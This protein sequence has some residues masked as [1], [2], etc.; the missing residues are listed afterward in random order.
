MQSI[1]SLSD[2]ELLAR[3]PD[4]VRTERGAMADVIVHL[5]EIGRRRLYLDQACSS[6]YSYCRERLSFSEDEALKRV[7][8]A[9]LVERLPRALAELETGSIHLTGLFLLSRHLTEE[10]ADTLLGEARGKSRREIEKVIASWF[11]RPDVPERIEA[12]P[13]SL[14]LGAS[15]TPATTPAA[16]PA[17][18]P[19]TGNQQ[20]SRTAPP[21]RLE[22]LSETRYR[23]EFTASAALHDKIERA[24]ELLSHSI[25]DGDLATLIERGLDEIIERET[26][27]RMGAGKKRKSRAPAKSRTPSPRSR[28]V[29]LEVACIVR[30]RDGHQCTFVDP[31]GRRCSERRFITIEHRQPFAHGGPAT[32]ENLT[33]LCRAHNAHSARK[34]FRRGAHRE[35]TRRANES[36]SGESS[37][38]QG[39]RCPDPPRVSQTRSP[40]RC[41]QD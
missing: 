8:V 4:L 25:P 31:K 17:A 37:R 3:M 5:V 27:R 16:T 21:P 9:R 34:V 38:A 10:N 1:S 30:E 6:L 12:E 35:A 22:P 40:A 7:R 39:S 11:P 29:P 19:G 33:L 41:P 26:R 20:R 24:R 15:I 28:H 36:S 32:P 13:Q 18:C 14:P 23:V 2:S